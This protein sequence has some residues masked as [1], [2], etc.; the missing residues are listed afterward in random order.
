MTGKRVLIVEDGGASYVLPAARSL[1]RAGWSVGL[2]S[3]NPN[4]RARGSRAVARHHTIPKPEDDLDAFVEAVN[5]AVAEIGYDV[6]LP[7]DDIELLALSMRRDQLDAIVPYASHE[8]VLRA[9]DKL[10]LTEAATA[11]GVAVPRTELAT[12][13]AIA[14]FPLPVMV[15]SRLHWTAGTGASVRHLPVRRCVDHDAVRARVAEI[16]AAGGSAILQ[17]PLAGR[18][19]AVSVVIDRD[20]R[21]VANSEQTTLMFSL[22]GPSTRAVTIDPEP[23]LLDDVTSLLRELGWFG[24]ANLQ[25]MQPEGARPHLIDFNGRLYGSLA[26]ALR[27]GVEL[28]AIWAA[29]ATGASPEGPVTARAGVRFQELEQDLLRARAE[30][31]GGLGLD[32]ARCLAFAPGAAHSIWS[33]RDPVPALHW[34]GVLGGQALRRLFRLGRGK[35]SPAQ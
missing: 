20:G 23:E 28:P 34:A 18:Q 33:A 14:S 17:E 7:T 6:L 30:R 8:V 10:E 21:I 4:P 22:T 24:L 13:D 29:C 32:V 31:H 19:V 26:L 11:S 5:R 1:A 9:V 16:E 12:A 25:F 27:A 15:K 2:G 35:R 3:P